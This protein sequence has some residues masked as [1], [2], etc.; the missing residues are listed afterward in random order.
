MK[1]ESLIRWILGLLV[2]L[3]LPVLPV[4]AVS[5]TVLKTS[6]P[7]FVTLTIEITGKGSV[8]IGDQKYSDSQTVSIPRNAQTVVSFQSATG[9][10]LSS[11]KLNGNDI[12][13]QLDGSSLVIDSPNQN[14]TLSV[15]FLRKSAIWPGM[16]P[17][18][19]DYQIRTQFFLCMLSLVSLLLLPLTKRRKH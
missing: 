12:S 13:Q 1:R 14:M 5:N 9:Y 7:D 10:R 17:P 4:S 11:I 6:V 15:V 2:A 8:W 18:T 16:N 3:L 19:G